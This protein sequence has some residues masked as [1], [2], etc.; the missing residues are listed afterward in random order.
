MGAI[1]DIVAAI[2]TRLTTLGYKATDEVFN[3][4]AVPNSIIDKAYRIETR[5]VKNE[6]H[7]N[8][9]ANPNEEISVYIAYKAKRNTRTVWKTAMSDRET[10]EKDVINAAAIRALASDPLV[11]MN[12]EA[13]TTK[14]LGDYLISR[15]VFMV[16]Y[17]RDITP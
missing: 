1:S 11:T 15:L 10:I 8:N 7:L 16:D 13:T 9:E 14:Y 4:D 12:G 6:Y 2:E 17:L 3:F 5:L